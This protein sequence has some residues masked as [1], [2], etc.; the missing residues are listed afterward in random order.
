MNKIISGQS[1]WKYWIEMAKVWSHFFVMIW[2]LFIISSGIYLFS[3]GFL[4]SRRTHT[5]TNSCKKL[6]ACD[7]N[8]SEVNECATFTADEEIFNYFFF[9]L[10]YPF[11]GNGLFKTAAKCGW[12]VKNGWGFIAWILLTT[13]DTHHF[14]CYRCIEIWI[15]L[16]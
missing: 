4:L 8:D 16:I 10:K 2:V 7:P 15:R 1:L 6:T 9:F 13:K 5:E 14:D 12:I 11:S 3:R